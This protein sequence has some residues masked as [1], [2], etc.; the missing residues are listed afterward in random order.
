MV[1]HP[2]EWK[3]FEEL[4]DPVFAKAFFWKTKG[5]KLASKYSSDPD[6]HN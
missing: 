1:H 3:V 2:F 4:L 5:R 6:M